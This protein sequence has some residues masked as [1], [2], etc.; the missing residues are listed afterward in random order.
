[1]YFF[2]QVLNFWIL[3]LYTGSITLDHQSPT[4]SAL[5]SRLS[6]QDVADYATLRS[7]QSLQRPQLP[8]LSSNIH[9]S[10]SA[11]D[12]FL[13][14]LNVSNSSSLNRER[15]S[16]SILSSMRRLKVR[17]LDRQSTQQPV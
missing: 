6:Q 1:M 9:H 13:D 14:D 8:N 2:L 11:A 10:L 7:L 16:S 5:S 12:H 4:H 3:F 17:S 15:H